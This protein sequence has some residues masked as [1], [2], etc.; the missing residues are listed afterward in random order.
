MDYSPTALDILDAAQELAQTRGYNG[1]SYKD[2]ADRVGIRTASIHYHFPSKGDLGRAMADQYRRFV[3]SA[4]ADI[5]V[6]VGDPAGARGSGAPQR[7]RRYAALLEGVL[8]NGNRM[9]LGG[10]L[11]SDYATLP[12]EVQHEVSRFITENERWLARVLAEGREAGTL[13]FSGTPESA[14][15]T[16]FSTLE[17]AMLNARGSEEPARFRRASAWFLDNIIPRPA[18]A[19]KRARRK[20]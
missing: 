20:G 15:T 14:A 1:F 6:D 16:F 2:I 17:G 11:A 4:L 19:R 18:S 10:M 13:V 12:P 8:T 5:D 3:S 7:L 9:C